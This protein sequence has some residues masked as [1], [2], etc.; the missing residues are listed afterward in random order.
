M[1][2]VLLSL[3]IAKSP[4]N[5]IGLL[6]GG[7]VGKSHSPM[8][9]KNV[10]KMPLMIRTR[11]GRAKESFFQVWHKSH[12]RNTKVWERC[13]ISLAFYSPPF[14]LLLLWMNIYTRMSTTRRKTF[15]PLQHV[16]CMMVVLSCLHVME[17]VT[18]HMWLS[19]QL[20]NLS[21]TATPGFHLRGET[22]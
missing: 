6:D 11:S 1:F 20:M 15:P 16:I 19:C 4:N 18:C 12:L 3:I 17:P 22:A 7:G 8:H 9:R 5:P 21:E 13:R 2:L 14:F 10:P